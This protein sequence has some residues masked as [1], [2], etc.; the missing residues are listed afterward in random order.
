MRPT[1]SGA[2]FDTG[3]PAGYIAACVGAALRRPELREAVHARVSALLG[4]AVMRVLVI[5]FPLPDPRI[6]NYNVFTAPSFF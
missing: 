4:G 3:R 6:D 2:R 1:Y 5:G